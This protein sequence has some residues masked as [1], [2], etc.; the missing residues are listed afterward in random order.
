MDAHGLGRKLLL[1]PLGNPQ[2]TPEKQTVGTVTTG[3]ELKGGAKS[4]EKQNLASMAPWKPFLETLR[5]WFLRRS[6]EGNSGD[7]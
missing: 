6:P 3:A 4:T 7:V 5:T 1:T 2:E